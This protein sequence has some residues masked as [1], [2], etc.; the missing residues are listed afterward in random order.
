[1]ATTL[2][3]HTGR[4]HVGAAGTTFLWDL[5]VRKRAGYWSDTEPLR[6][7]WLFPTIP[8]C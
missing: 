2:L 1:M 8:S 7:V 5:T 3:V 6:G 4:L